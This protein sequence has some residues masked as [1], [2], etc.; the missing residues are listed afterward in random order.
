MA[1]LPSDTAEGAQVRRGG[2]GRAGAGA[3]VIAVLIASWGSPGCHGLLNYGDEG[4]AVADKD[5]YVQMAAHSSA[6]ADEDPEE[7]PL[8]PSQEGPRC[9]GEPRDEDFRDVTLEDVLRIA[10]SNNT[11]LRDDNQ[12]L[13]SGNVLLANGDAV[14]SAFDPTI[15]ATSG[16][17]GNR[18]VESALAD[19]DPWLSSGMTTGRNELLQNNQFLAGGVMPQALF[20]ENSTALNAQL[21][22]RWATG[23]S[24]ALINNWSY[25]LNNLSSRLYPSAYTGLLRGE[26]R[27]PLWSGYGREFTEIAGPIGNLGTIEQP[28][29]RGIAIARINSRISLLAFEYQIQNLIRD[30]QALYW[31]LALAYETHHYQAVARDSAKELWEKV[32]GRAEAGLRGTGA[33]DE[34]QAREYYYQQEVLTQNALSTIYE[35][36]G[37]LRRLI[38]LPLN[39]GKIL[40]CADRPT[41]SLVDVNWPLSLSE[42]LTRRVELRRQKSEIQKLEL[43]VRAA[44]SLTRP[45]VD[46]ATGYQLNGFG[47]QLFGGRDG[48]GLPSAF[49][50]L[51]GAGQTGWDAG[52]QF[53]MPIGY[54]AARNQV[55]N[56]ELRLAKARAVLSAQES[57]VTHEL[58]NTVQRIKRWHV[59]TQTN[60]RRVEAAEERVKAV[61]A[62]YF[63]GRTTLDLLLRSQAS[64][65]Q[66]R[67]DHYRSLVEYNKAL[68]EKHYR[69]GSLLE[70]VNVRLAEGAW[71]PQAFAEELQR[72]YERIRS[73]VIGGE[74]SPATRG[75]VIPASAE[76][77][78]APKPK[79][80]P[81]APEWDDSDPAP[82]WNDEDEREHEADA[83]TQSDDPAGN[84]THAD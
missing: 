5:H 32:Q 48:T 82:V 81:A 55:Q 20:A 37:R 70:H 66:A 27:Q 47:S 69:E 13:S 71:D 2:A 38:G 73:G 53:L 11:I 50:S 35:L 58:A 51:A 7:P 42:A 65:A 8:L 76:E 3:L 39:D 14:P 4:P 43:Q 49:Q 26:L 80:A 68:A 25:S 17:Y 15:Q 84:R 19:F 6:A 23:G 60:T 18:G 34:A 74:D 75:A 40:R 30:T 24:A 63:V 77:K 29:N 44:Q 41:A 16:I 54:R 78:S 22:K 10:L 62:D 61:E 57:E 67:V 28:L 21:Q 46:L 83:A 12:F 56:L 9:I 64:L 59:S 31:E 52:V 36:E 1:V 79:D 33:A 45:R 72:N